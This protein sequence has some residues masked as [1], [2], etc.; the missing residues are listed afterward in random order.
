MTEGRE[1]GF[2]HLKKPDDVDVVIELKDWLFALEG[3][4]EMAE[5]W[6]FSSNEDV[7]REERCWHTTF[8]S[9]QVKAKSTPKNV[10]NGKAQLHRLQKYPIELVTVK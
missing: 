5:G 1:M 7:G 8:H 2:S 4:Q 9:L 10:Q 3:S 6:W